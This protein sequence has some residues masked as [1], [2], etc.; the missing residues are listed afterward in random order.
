[1][2]NRNALELALS[3]RNTPAS[4][5]QRI[6]REHIAIK[7]IRLSEDEASLIIKSLEHYNE[8]NS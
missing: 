7:V 1:M 4:E 5:T 6:G 3:I 8:T 2:I